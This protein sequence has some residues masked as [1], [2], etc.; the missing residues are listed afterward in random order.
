[1]ESDDENY[2][3]MLPALNVLDYHEPKMVAKLVQ[4][5]EVSIMVPNC[6]K[7][8]YSDANRMR[9]SGE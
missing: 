6:D 7:W 9:R 1:M 5:I 2:R 8:K 3:P 4:S